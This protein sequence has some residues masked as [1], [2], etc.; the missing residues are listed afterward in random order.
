MTAACLIVIGI[1]GERFALVIP[2]TAYPL[3]F[4][5]GSIEGIWGEVGSFPL[6]PVELFM[7]IG[8]FAL[9]GLFFLLGLKYLAL[10]PANERSEPLDT[11]A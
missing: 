3:A 4:Y 9:M 8:I 5:P 10:L 7:S 2:G 1:F 6:R 11:S